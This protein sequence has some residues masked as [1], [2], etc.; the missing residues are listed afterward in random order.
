ML[1]LKPGGFVQTS[2]MEE[3]TFFASM[4]GLTNAALFFLKKTHDDGTLGVRN[5]VAL[6]PPG[7]LFR[8]SA[9]SP[10]I[11]ATAPS[12]LIT[13]RAFSSR[14]D[15]DVA[16]QFSYFL[17]CPP[18]TVFFMDAPAQIRPY[19]ASQSPPEGPFP[20]EWHPLNIRTC[21]PFPSSPSPIFQA[22]PLYTA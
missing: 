8:A 2:S 4:V 22:C 13:S 12:P 3:L 5:C 19:V 21:G 16:A 14:G 1:F 18:L 11:L 9:I 10:R 6:N 7:N 20:A 17:S 15:Y